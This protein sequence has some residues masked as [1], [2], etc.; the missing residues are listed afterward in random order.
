MVVMVNNTL[1]GNIV[2]RE[3]VSEK[4]LKVIENYP[5]LELYGSFVNHTYHFNAPNYVS[6]SDLDIF[7]VEELD[8][9][10]VDISQEI[11]HQIYE[12]CGLKLDVSIRQQ[13]IHTN[14]IEPNLAES[15]AFF[16]LLYK[17]KNNANSVCAYYQ[18]YQ[19]SKFFL[20]SLSPIIYFN[21]PFCFDNAKS[22]IPKNMYHWL[23]NIKIGLIDN[24]INNSFAWLTELIEDVEYKSVL[25]SIINSKSPSDFNA[26]LVVKKVEAFRKHPNI[27]L[28][29]ENKLLS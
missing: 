6:F 21:D 16:E 14:D 5:S 7:A 20:R 4:V 24:T 17:L 9:S 15:I 23:L 11:S 3:Q 26:Y 27:Y 8:V 1:V 29:L 2:L 18:T 12:K 19:I 28:D 22:K 25:K 13:R 10:K